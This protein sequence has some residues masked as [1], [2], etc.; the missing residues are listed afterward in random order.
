MKVRIYGPGCMKCDTLFDLVTRAAGDSGITCE[1][2]K[3]TD[4]GDII[5]AGVITTPG[6]EIDGEVILQGKVPSLDHL[7]TILGDHAA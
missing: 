2:E 5:A 7:M 3:V 1:I 4:L 6:L